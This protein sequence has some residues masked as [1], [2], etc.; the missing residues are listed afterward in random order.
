MLQE[1]CRTGAEEKAITQWMLPCWTS[2][3]KVKHVAQGHPDNNEDKQSPL[4]SG[5]RFAVGETSRPSRKRQRKQRKEGE[6]RVVRRKDRK[7][8]A[9]GLEVRLQAGL[10]AQTTLGLGRD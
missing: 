9:C 2:G 7:G 6:E 5:S 3:L 10:C 1:D 8:T 4:A